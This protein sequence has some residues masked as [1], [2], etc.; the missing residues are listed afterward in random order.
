M[1][2][3]SKKIDESLARLAWSLWTEIGV[4]GLERKHRTFSVAPEELIILTSVLAEFDPRLRDESLDWCTRYHCF[5]SPIRLHILAKKYEDF[6]AEP[7]SIFSK[8][9]NA[10]ADMRTKW[11]VF[12][13]TT[14]FKI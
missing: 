2:T 13:E 9:L 3:V 8:T 1:R 14:S 7:F 6:I 12:T 4:A 11:I 10:I 5:I